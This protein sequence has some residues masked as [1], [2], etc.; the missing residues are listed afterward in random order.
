MSD[1]DSQVEDYLA[2]WNEGDAA[3]RA[4]LAAALFSPEAE[5]V[6]PI[7][8]AASPEGI[9]TTIGAVRDQF[10]GWTFRQLGAVDAHNGFARFRWALSPDAAAAPEDA[11]VIGFDVAS[12]AEDGSI[13]SVIGFLDRVPQS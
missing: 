9:A 5:Y 10:P 3:R 12:F 2:V 1:F 13:E 4:E 6:D 11:P 7:V 8:T